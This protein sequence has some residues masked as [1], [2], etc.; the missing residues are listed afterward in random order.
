MAANHQETEIRLSINELISELVTVRDKK[1][2]KRWSE[3][4]K[5]LYF[6]FVNPLLTDE[7][8]IN[9]L[10]ALALHYNKKGVYRESCTLFEDDLP[11]HFRRALN[12][13]RK[14]YADKSHLGLGFLELDDEKAKEYFAYSPKGLKAVKVM[15]KDLKEI[16]ES[17]ASKRED[18]VAKIKVI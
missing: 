14:L 9:C 13:Y 16:Q 6:H 15:L 10:A 12:S 3:I 1:D 5:E 7:I 18:F 8:R 4:K 11:L 17:L 2:H